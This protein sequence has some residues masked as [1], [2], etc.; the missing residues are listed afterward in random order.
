M[1]INYHWKHFSIYLIGYLVI[2]AMFSPK[3][4][5]LHR[6]FSKQFFS[7]RFGKKNGFRKKLIS[8]STT[9]REMSFFS[10]S[11]KISHVTGIKATKSWLTCS[12]LL[13]DFMLQSSYSKGIV[14][15]VL[16]RQSLVSFIGIC[17]RAKHEHLAFRKFAQILS[18]I[19]TFAKDW[20]MVHYEPTLNY[21]TFFFLPQW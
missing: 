4:N 6:F 8:P 13:M 14:P 17:S 19:T 7:N 20:C 9:Y 16:F 10:H 1:L 5:V 21:R 15:S 18:Y 12:L 2:L 3:M 11:Y